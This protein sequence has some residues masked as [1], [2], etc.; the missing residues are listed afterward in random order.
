MEPIILKGKLLEEVIWLA[1]T[2]EISGA[3]HPNLSREY[4]SLEDTLK[5]VGCIEELGLVGRHIESDESCISQLV[6]LRN[7]GKN[8]IVINYS[9]GIGGSDR[10]SHMPALLELL[11]IPYTGGNVLNKVICLSKPETKKIL[12][13]HDIPTPNFD[14]ARS[15]D[16]RLDPKLSFP[17]FLKPSREGSSIGISS[18]SLVE[19][20]REFYVLLEKML[21]KY[22]Q[23]ILIEEYLSGDEFSVGLLG[24]RLLP[25]IEKSYEGD[26]QSNNIKYTDRVKYISPAVSLSEPE[27]ERIID[28]ARRSFN[29]THCLDLARLDIRLDGNRNPSV[30]EINSPPGVHPGSSFTYAMSAAGISPTDMIRE[31]LQNATKRYK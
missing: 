31:I 26:F 9:E 25:L 17:L 5:I 4:D 12:R 27:Q 30:L 16:Y 13:Y 19:G 20:I 29:V 18:D 28:I 8:I 7:Q 2:T 1:N 6:E 15:I 24:N 14:E 11:G 23:P 3:N 10:E 21:D 22:K